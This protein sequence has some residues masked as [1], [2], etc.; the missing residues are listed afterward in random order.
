[1]F[2]LFLIANSYLAYILYKKYFKINFCIVIG[3]ILLNLI[4]LVIYCNNK[5]I[6]SIAF[7]YILVLLY[8]SFIIDIKEMWI[9]DVTIFGVLILKIINTFIDCLIYNKNV[10]YEGVMFITIIIMIFVLLEVLLKKELMGFGDL[11]LFFVLSINYSIINVIYLLVLSSFIGII[12]YYIFR[13]KNEFP[14][15]PSIIIAYIILEII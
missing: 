3:Y 14:F 13:K 9:S 4:S 7:Y 1:M 10:I 5:A 12:Y 6:D 11:K 8:L 2:I 15:G